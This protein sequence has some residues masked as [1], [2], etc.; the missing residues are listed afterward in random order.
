MDA[1]LAQLWNAFW[2]IVSTPSEIV[3]ELRFL[4]SRKAL[5]PMVL[6]LEG[7]VTETIEDPRKALLP[8]TATLEGISAPRTWQ[9]QKAQDPIL[10]TPFSMTTVRIFWL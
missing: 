8:I 2:P 1:R 4:H 9:F 10:V 7:M 3:A 6:T 5:S